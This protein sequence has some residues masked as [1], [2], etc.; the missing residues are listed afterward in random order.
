VRL[1]RLALC[2]L[3]VSLVATAP[4]AHAATK[5]KPKPKPKPV[6]NLLVDV[7][8]DG[9]STVMPTVEGAPMDITGA[10]IATGTKT[11]VAVLRVGT[12]DASSYNWAKLGY[13]VSMQ[14]KILGKT[15]TF[16]RKR[17]AGTAETYED[18]F[19]NGP[20][21]SVAVTPT[22]IAWT[23]DRT[24]IDDLKK[25]KIVITNLTASSRPFVSNGDA[26]SST[27]TYADKYPSCVRAS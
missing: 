26:G 16:E 8:G 5:K 4:T 25:P 9:R 17:K 18:T 23:I 3:A 6:C 1:R 19:Q 11:L 27:K 14:F 13:G 2:T 24:A 15:Y 22:S 20:V 21:K 12:T 7:S 10:D